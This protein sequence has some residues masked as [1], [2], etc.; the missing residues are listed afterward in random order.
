MLLEPTQQT[1][2]ITKAIG[3][4]TAA[5][6]GQ[7]RRDE[8]NDAYIQHP[9]RVFHSIKKLC[10]QDL[11]DREL[12]LIT[13]LL[14]DTIE[15]AS[16]IGAREAIEDYIRKEFPDLVYQAV[17]RLT[18][19]DK[20][21]YIDYLNDLM[22]THE[23]PR[24]AHIAYVVKFFDVLDNSM[25]V[26]DIELLGTFRGTAAREIK[27]WMRQRLK[28]RVI[29][30][31]MISGHSPLS[32]QHTAN[33]WATVLDHWNEFDEQAIAWMSDD[34]KYNHWVAKDQIRLPNYL[35]C[36]KLP[37]NG[38]DLRNWRNS[39]AAIYDAMESYYPAPVGSDR[40]EEIKGRYHSTVA[41]LLEFE[42]FLAEL[43]LNI[44][45]SN[46]PLV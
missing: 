8:P 34:S 29:F 12:Y 27:K 42:K 24:V 16:T 10:P 33:L 3:F 39:N 21:E 31:K 32:E 37:I 43:K 35:R 4:A 46:Q 40:Y 1:D 20:R 45:L 36:R 19:L 6:Y 9:L 23:D 14:H 38:L 25:S 15:D 18:H 2:L 44:N 7:Y 22:N 17:L 5:H 41:D 11:Q 13:A 28:Y 26:L 30:E